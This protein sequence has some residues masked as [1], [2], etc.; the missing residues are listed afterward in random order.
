MREMAGCKGKVI[1]FVVPY[2]AGNFLTRER[3]VSFSK[4]FPP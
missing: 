4:D 3:T 1:R 2:I